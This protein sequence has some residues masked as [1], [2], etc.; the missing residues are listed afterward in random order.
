MEEEFT[1]FEDDDI[2]VFYRAQDNVY[3]ALDKNEERASMW[4]Y[5]FGLSPIYLS[6]IERLRL[7]LAAITMMYKGQ[8]RKS[9]KGEGYEGT[10]VNTGKKGFIG[11]YFGHG[12]KGTIN[13]NQGKTDISFLVLQSQGRGRER[14]FLN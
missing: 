11:T 7:P 4:E 9:V 8:K 2:R 3:V 12:F 6:E 1:I 10:L 13:T 5:A 14:D